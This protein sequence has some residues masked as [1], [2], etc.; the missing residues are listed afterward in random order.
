MHERDTTP[1]TRDEPTRV[2]NTT[3][4]AVEQ[5]VTPE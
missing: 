5:G 1:T 4:A 3:A 2:P